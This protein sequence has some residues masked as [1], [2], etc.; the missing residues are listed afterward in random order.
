MPQ[1]EIGPEHVFFF[2]GLPNLPIAASEEG[3]CKLP[4]QEKSAARE[5]TRIS[6]EA[7]ELRGECFPR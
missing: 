3:Q 7:Y 1:Q 5:A 6:L 4:Q 2:L